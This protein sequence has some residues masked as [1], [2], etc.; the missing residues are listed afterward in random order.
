MQT[1]LHAVI[2]PTNYK[3]S[4]PISQI[5]HRSFVDPGFCLAR[6]L[7]K[8]KKSKQNEC[9]AK[10][11]SAGAG[12]ILGIKSPLRRGLKRKAAL[13]EDPKK[14]PWQSSVWAIQS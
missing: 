8:K 9:W 13:Q 4:W 2:I 11:F 14:H 6:F 3:Q 7:V 1:S 10:D 5:S 12:S